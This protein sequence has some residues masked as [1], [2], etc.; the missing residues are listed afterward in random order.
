MRAPLLLYPLL[1]LLLFVT[2]A[3]SWKK[4]EFRNCDQTPFCKRARSRKP[5]SCNLRVADVSISDGDLIAKL[6]PKEENPESEQPNKPLVLTLSVY[7]DG[8]M[9]VKIDEDQ[10][11]NPPKKRFEV[12]EVIEED[13]LNTKLWLT[14]VKEEQIDGVSSFSSV[15]Y[16][17]D[18][19]EGV[20]RHD[21]FEVFA[22][23]SGSGKRVL[24]INSNGL[25]DFEQ[26]R[27][28]KEGD[29]WEEKFRSHTDTRPYGPQS[30]SFDVSFYGADFVYGIPEHAT[31]F[32]LKPTKGPNVEEYSE[33]YR[34]FNLDVFEYL[35]E[36]PFGL[37][38]S[39][40]FM[41]S[42][43]K[44]RGS[45]G[46]FWLN[47]A[48]MQIDVLGSSWNSNES[49][50]IML[51]SDKHR[52][53]TLWMSESGVVDT[54]FFIGPGPKDV[55]RQYTS[56]TG[57]PSMPQL[58][59]TA[60][61]QCRW[62]YRDEEDVYNVDSKFDEHDIPYDVLWLDIEHTDGKKYFTWDRVLFPNPEEMQKKLAAKGRHM[63]TIVDPHI[64]RDESYHIH[65]EAS[66]KG[67]Y[68]KDAT[69][70]DYDGWCWPGSSSYT[71]LLNPEI[72]SW[73]S[74]KFSLDSYVGSTKYLYIWNDMNEPSVFNGPEVTMPRDA[75]HHGGVEHRELHNSYGYYFHMAT[76]DGLLKRGDGKDRPFVLARAFFA[77]SQRYGAIWTGD[78]TA[79]WEHLRVSV[80][81]VLTLSISGIVFSGADV[82]GFFGNPDTEL[83]VRWYQVGAY[84]PFFRGHAHH[85]TKRREPWLFGER[86]TQLMREA[87]HVRYMYLPYFYTLF[88]EANSSGTPVA[89]PL[90]M[91]FPGDEKSFSNDEAFMVGNG[92]LVQGVYTEKAK[93]VSVYL[94]GEE[95]WYDLRSAS[96]YNGGHT[97]KYEVSEDSIPSFQRAGTIIPRKDRLRRSS[98]QMENDP[99]TLVIALNSSKAA[100]GELYIDDGKSYEFKQGAFIH[101]R[102]T[103]SN[104]RLISSNAAPSTAGSDTFSSECTVERIILLGL[105]PGAKTALIEPGNKK[106]EIELGPL[107]IQGNRGSVPTIRKPN[108]RITDDW[109]IQ[110][111]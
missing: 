107:F 82:G 37:Y 40:P 104:G 106:V 9:R 8:V 99:Y 89:R 94:P 28:K 50:K 63:V 87:I 70:K 54:F 20:L 72:R 42:H 66:E 11:L 29:D 26:L 27:E 39:I 17:S 88:R 75:L 16:L 13:F 33:P 48:E 108:V 52:I 41:I 109:S 22:R 30:I 61:H 2:S 53:D 59:A 12:P 23:E 64:K 65:K 67:Y 6:V 3:Y 76:S 4:E 32:A 105:S 81:M 47:A 24:S 79:E 96:A 44:A 51:P 98:T 14:R 60:Y 1:L 73:W 103:F 86:N 92:L 43:G 97:H 18:G 84:Y 25:F 102:F 74:D 90:W 80:P 83:L 31:S 110:I 58:F 57:R 34:L 7:Q 21:P 77:G 56:V 100:E 95:S 19:Y 15:F 101:R 45:S 38:G 68:V 5:G 49:S 78:N 85:D 10:N 93:H 36:S 46:F 62:N 69:G 91:E 55:V 71:D 111:L 35:H